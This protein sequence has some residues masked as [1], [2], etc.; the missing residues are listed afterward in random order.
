MKIAINGFGRIGRNV[1]KIACERP[2]MDI[3]AI[4]DIA[5]TEILAGLL[6]HDSTYGVYNRHVEVGRNSIMVDGKKI[7]TLAERSPKNL[8]WGDL[9]VDIVIESTGLFR[10]AESEKGGYKDHIKAGAGKVILT[11]PARDEIDR[12]IVLGVNDDS[13][14][15][16]SIAY[17]NASCTTNCLAPIVR[18]LHDSF[19]IKGG[20]MTTVQCV[21]QRSGAC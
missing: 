19:G 4:N 6:K 18:I 12:T 15:E 11:V 10:V 21:H 7:M 9:D 20:L 16:D 5:D 2:G 13:I 1:F 14:D 17:S 8:P 3:V